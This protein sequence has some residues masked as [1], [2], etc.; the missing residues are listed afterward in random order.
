MKLS[1]FKLELQPLTGLKL[2]LASDKHVGVTLTD[3]EPLVLEKQSF[4]TL[5]IKYAR[6]PLE[7]SN[8]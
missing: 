2:Q 5:R 4:R 8:A 1:N 7:E 3:S 6:F